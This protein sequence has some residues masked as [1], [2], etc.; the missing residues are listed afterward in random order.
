M[1]KEK[2]AERRVVA[3]PPDYIKEKLDRHLQKHGGSRSEFI[4]DA[5]KEKLEAI[6]AINKKTNSVSSCL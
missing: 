2:H 6:R 3:Y 1:E 4:T 5:I